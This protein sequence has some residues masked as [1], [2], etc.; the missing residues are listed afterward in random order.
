VS[1]RAGFSLAALLLAGCAEPIEQ[2]WAPPAT[3]Y[4]P[5]LTSEA[6]SSESAAEAPVAATP[7][8]EGHASFYSDRLA[9]HST[10]NGEPYDPR[11]FTAAHRT[12]PF[13]AVVD[14]ARADGR[15]VRVR[16]NDRGPHVRGRI[17][18]LSRRAAA[19]LGM[20]RAG[21]ARV[22]LRVLW[23]PSGARM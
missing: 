5:P 18:D 16:I 19:E 17:I 9:G 10:A 20:V 13:G 21:T 1:R 23:V 8:E 11:A 3:P 2:G 15:H 22:V 6:L 7:F 4:S 14:V 12:L